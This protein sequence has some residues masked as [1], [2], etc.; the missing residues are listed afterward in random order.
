MNKFLRAHRGATGHETNELEERRKREEKK[1]TTFLITK[2]GLQ[3]TKC[4]WIFFSAYDERRNNLSW[5]VPLRKPFINLNVTIKH[6]KGSP[7]CSNLY[8]H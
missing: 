6:G 3:R 2:L 4:S 7:L 8:Y 1:C 5:L